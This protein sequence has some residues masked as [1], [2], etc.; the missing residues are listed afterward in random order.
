M[1]WNLQNLNY[2]KPTGASVT[3]VQAAGHRAGEGEPLLFYSG[4]SLCFRNLSENEWASANIKAL[5]KNPRRQR[6]QREFE[7]KQVPP[8]Q[9]TSLE[10]HV[11]PRRK[12]PNVH[13]QLHGVKL[14]LA[15]NR[16]PAGPGS[17]GG[18]RRRHSPCRSPVAP[19]G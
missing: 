10:S 9:F 8:F 4:G 7:N 3:K 15:A 16:R 12:G 2:L 6:K 5:P 14:W 17:G 13:P 11:K 1:V 19:R 18:A